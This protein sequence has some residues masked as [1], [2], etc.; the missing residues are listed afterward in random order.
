MFRIR[1]RDAGF[2]Y[3]WTSPPMSWEEAVFACLDAITAWDYVDCLD[4]KGNIAMTGG[5]WAN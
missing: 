5:R 4:E 3:Y 1:F 2:L